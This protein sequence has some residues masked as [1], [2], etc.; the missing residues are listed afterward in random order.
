M[1][2]SNQSGRTSNKQQLRE[3]TWALLARR[4]VGRF[5]LPLE[6]RI[7][8][9]AGAEQAAERLAALPEWRTARTLKCNPDAPQRPV[10]LRALREGK[11]VYVAVPRLRTAKCFLRLDP[12]RIPAEHLAEAAT[13]GGAAALGVPVAPEELPHIDLVVA[14]S[15]AVNRRGARVGKGGG[16]SDLE[17]ALAAELGAVDARTVVVTTVHDLQLIQGEI[18][19]TAHDVPVDIVVT[20]TRTIRARRV[21]TRSHRIRWKEL[22]AAQLA[23]MPPLSKLRH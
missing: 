2:N 11:Q 5:P 23:A 18:P 6:D 22:D 15:V 13:I 21:R 14:G 12:R 9:F 8:N 1:D 10:R 17:F 19:M 16:Y 20:P 7:P 4:R 3:R